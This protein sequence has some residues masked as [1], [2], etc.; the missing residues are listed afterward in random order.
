MR[1]ILVITILGCIIL[2]GITFSENSWADHEEDEED[3]D[4]DDDDDDRGLNLSRGRFNLA[5]MTMLTTVGSIVGVGGYAGYKL[6]S[7]R[8]KVAQSKKKT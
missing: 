4:E 5:N 3:E 1:S 7:I 8:R 6:V 2:S